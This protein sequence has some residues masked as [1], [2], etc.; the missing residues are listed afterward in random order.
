VAAVA[1]G[2]GPIVV[3]DN[4][5]SFTYNLVQVRLHAAAAM[6]AGTRTHLH[7]E[8]HDTVSTTEE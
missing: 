7:P 2:K 4:Y 6:F 1:A 3:I 8:Q 5:D